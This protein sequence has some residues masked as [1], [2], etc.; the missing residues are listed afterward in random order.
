VLT[1]SETWANEIK[2]DHGRDVKVITNG[3]DRMDFEES[4]INSVGDKFIISHSGLLNEFRNP[5]SLWA[6]LRVLCQEDEDFAKLLQIEFCGI[7]DRKVLENIQ[8]DKILGPRFKFKD[9]VSHSEV[10]RIYNSS[11][12]LLLL[13]NDTDNAKGHLPGKLFEYLASNRNILAIGDVAGDSSKIIQETETGITCD[14]ADGD[15]IKKAISSF[16]THFKNGTFPN[17][18]SIEQYSRK[19]LTNKLVDVLEQL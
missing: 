6:A 1:V 15:S 12:V 13:L 8:S 14:P 10:L 16:F 17:S 19:T 4:T 11:S 2:N 18:V 9:Y 5:K 7:V 3:F